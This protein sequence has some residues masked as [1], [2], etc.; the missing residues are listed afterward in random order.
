MPDKNGGFGTLPIL[1][2]VLCGGFPR[3]FVSDLESAH[4]S[5]STLFGGRETLGQS[6]NEHDLP[7]QVVISATLPVICMRATSH[8]YGSATDLTEAPQR[9]TVE[10]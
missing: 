1:L 5:G 4:L 7:N 3:K 8:L 2:I 6:E 10:H 9:M